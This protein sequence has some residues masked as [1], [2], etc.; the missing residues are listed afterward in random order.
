[1][2]RRSLQIGRDV[3][4]GMCAARSLEQARDRFTFFLTVKQPADA[5]ELDAWGLS[6]ISIAASSL[7]C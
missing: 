3:T 7:A 6:L 2:V 1:M 4:S 5:V